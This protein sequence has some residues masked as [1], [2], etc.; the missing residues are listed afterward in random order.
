MIARRRLRV[1]RVRRGE[2][3]GQPRQLAAGALNVLG[4]RRLGGGGALL[5]GGEAGGARAGRAEWSG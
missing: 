3:R 4:Q 5:G 2:L 1:Q